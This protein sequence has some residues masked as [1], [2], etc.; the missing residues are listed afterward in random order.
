MTEDEQLESKGR[1]YDHFY[2]IGRNVLSAFESAGYILTATGPANQRRFH[3]EAK[4]DSSCVQ[5]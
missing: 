3:L 4:F 1:D 2:A 5:L